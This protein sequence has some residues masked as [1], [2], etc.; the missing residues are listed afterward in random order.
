MLSLL[1]A[2]FCLLSCNLCGTSVSEEIE[3]EILLKIHF[4]KKHSELIELLISN[5]IEELKVKLSAN[6]HKTQ[7]MQETLAI[8]FVWGKKDL[9][10]YLLNMNTID[11][12]F[13]LQVILYPMFFSFTFNLP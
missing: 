7:T 1:S 8:F 10:E 5:E 3:A 12:N 13:K 11:I 9:C 2:N 6:I 4:N